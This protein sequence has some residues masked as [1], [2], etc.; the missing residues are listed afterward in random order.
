MSMIKRK[1][2]H[3]VLLMVIGFSNLHAYAIDFI[4]TDHCN[5][6][7]YVHEF[8]Q[9][10]T[11]DISDDICDVHHAFHIPFLLPELNVFISKKHQKDALFSDPSKHDFQNFESISRPPITHS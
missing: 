7:E 9:N 6:E 11:L 5:I 3:I 10:S 4:D 2:I 1:L 8:T